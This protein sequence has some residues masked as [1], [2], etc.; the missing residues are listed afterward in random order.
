MYDSM[1][2]LFVYGTLMNPDV[3]HYVMGRVPT[4]Y[5]GTLKDYKKIGLNIVESPG[6]SVEGFYFEVKPDD[7][8]A[9]DA[10]EGVADGLYKRIKVVLEEG[11]ECIAY[12]KVRPDVR[13]NLED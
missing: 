10:Y 9:L 11:E 5:S 8:K 4:R 13:I 1:K 7:L 2:L 3:M 12:Q 6:D